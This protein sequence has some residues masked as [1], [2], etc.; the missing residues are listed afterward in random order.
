MKVLLF[1]ID[2]TLVLSGGA[3]VKALNQAFYDMFHVKNVLAHVN[4]AGRT[5]TSI[6]IDALE[7][8]Q[9][10]VNGST[11]EE[12]KELYYNLLIDE[13]KVPS[14]KKFVMPGIMPLL[15]E[16]HQRPSVYLGL[17]TGNWETSGR[18]KLKHFG[19]DHYFSFGAFADDSGVRDELLPFAVERYS[20][21]F[22]QIPQP[23]QVYVIGDTPADIQCAR[24][25]GA[26]SV[27]VGAAHY[28]V[29]QLEKYNPDYLFSDFS[30]TEEIL[31]VLG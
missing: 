14:D 12:F 9:I 27:A 31:S 11:I 16:L 23:H 28:T 13:I 1:D 29:E 20:K 30:N 5:D 26:V 22:N 8:N 6:L 4:L 25:H 17:L 3:G 19:L 24:P 10:N 7:E 21:K 2:G 15:Q 18:I